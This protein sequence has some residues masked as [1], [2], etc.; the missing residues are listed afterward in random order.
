MLSNQLCLKKEIPMKLNGKVTNKQPS[1]LNQKWKN[2]YP[3]LQKV[4]KNP[5][6]MIKNL[7]LIQK[8]KM[9]IL[10]K[11]QEVPEAPKILEILKL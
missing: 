6:K 10:K 5:S 1:N 9:I 7:N 2:K 4:L 8:V 11:A 3:Y